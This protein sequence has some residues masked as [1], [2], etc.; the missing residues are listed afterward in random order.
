[1]ATRILKGG[2]RSRQPHDAPQAD[3]QIAAA[4]AHREVGDCA[5]V[6]RRTTKSPGRWFRAS[7]T[8]QTTP[9][10][11]SAA[12]ASGYAACVSYDVDGL[13]WEDPPVATVVKAVLDGA[14]P[15]RS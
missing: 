5:A 2:A 3:A 10:I 6:L 7:G 1:L 11:R 12:A 13:D 9:L 4:E 15:G 14:R 8:Q